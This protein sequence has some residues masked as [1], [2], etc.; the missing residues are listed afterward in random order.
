MWEWPGRSGRAG[1]AGRGW[2]RRSGS[3]LVVYEVLEGWS[4]LEGAGSAGV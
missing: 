4:L 1:F 2:E 3:G